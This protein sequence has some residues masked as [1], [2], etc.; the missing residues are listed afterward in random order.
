MIDPPHREGIFYRRMIK[1]TKVVFNSKNMKSLKALVKAKVGKSKIPMLDYLLVNI[2]GFNNIITVSL[3]TLDSYIVREMTVEKIENQSFGRFLIPIQEI[4]NIKSNMEGTTHTFQALDYCKLSITTGSVN[5]T[6]QSFDPEEYIQPPKIKSSEKV[7]AI[8]NDTLK[9]LESACISASDSETR[10]ILTV[11]NL[12]DSNIISTDSH[13]MYMAADKGRLSDSEINLI[14]SFVKAL[15]DCEGSKFFGVLS[16]S[17]SGDVIVET[18]DTTYYSR[19]K[20]GNY[21]DTSR[22]TPGDF[23]QEI[24]ITDT[25]R[26]K[27]VMT[28]CYELNKKDKNNVVALE[29]LENN[30][31]SIYARNVEGSEIKEILPVT[32]DK[33]EADLK[34]SFSTK[35]F[36]DAL[37]QLDVTKFIKLKFVGAMR[38]FILES[39][40]EDSF[41]LILPVRIY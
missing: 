35:Y 7:F 12:K 8:R 15:R 40:A 21:P 1:L 16:L 26:L 29:I 34:I 28:A 37:K 9:K 22:L 3:A 25:V 13:R 24:T 23:K 14:P 18:M 38:P 4:K 32:V 31:I 33:K 5:K 11:V 39:S 2:V 17:S 10:P 6:V 20:E 27:E 30:E 36:L 19:I 41:S